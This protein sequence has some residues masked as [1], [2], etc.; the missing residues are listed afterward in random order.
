[1]K[2]PFFFQIFFLRIFAS[3][4]ARVRGSVFKM[5]FRALSR[6]FESIKTSPGFAHLLGENWNESHKKINNKVHARNN[7]SNDKGL[8]VNV[9][10]SQKKLSCTI[11]DKKMT[12]KWN[13]RKF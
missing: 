11:F 6:E 13:E 8:E 4:G 1:M 9:V 7:L 12:G 3:Y 10:I 2:K 5:E